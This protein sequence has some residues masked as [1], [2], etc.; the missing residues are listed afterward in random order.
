MSESFSTLFCVVLIVFV[1]AAVIAYA[2]R[3]MS[4]SAP[5]RL[6]GVIAAITAFAGVVPAVIY[7]ALAAAP[8]ST[9]PVAP[10]AA[11]V[12]ATATATPPTSPSP[13]TRGITEPGPAAVDRLP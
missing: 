12:P 6:A 5:A 11:S 4:T 7:A 3:R 13:T 8:T 10:A 2:V 9:R 1:L